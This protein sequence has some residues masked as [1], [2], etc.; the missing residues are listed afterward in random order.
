METVTNFILGGS[1]ITADSHYSH[2]IKRCSFLG[3]KRYDQPREH[4]KKQRHYFASKG[5][6]S[7]GYDFS[8]SQ[9]WI[10]NMDCIKS[11]VPNN[12]CFWAVVLDKTLESHLDS[13][14]IKPVNP[15]GNQPWEF[16]GRT[17][18]EAEIPVLWPPNAKDWLIGK[19][20]RKSGW[21]RMRWLDGITD[22][23]D[24]S[25]SKLRELVMEREDWQAAVN[26][27]AKSST[28]LSVSVELNCEWINI[29]SISVH[30]H[31]N[32]Q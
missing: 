29:Y 21:Q 1:K 31:T 26:G 19:D 15:K 23:K 3:R 27:F 16:I 18:V 30:W 11:W 7:Q 14:E 9:A 28:Q 12:W 8:S 20:Q 4:I 6:S 13:K 2:E 25:L 10:W 5:L 24:M 17:D 32:R 22:S